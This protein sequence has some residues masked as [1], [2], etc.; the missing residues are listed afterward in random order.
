MKTF[1]RRLPKFE[2]V[3]PK[4]A[5]EA[6]AFLSGN[7]GQVKVLAGGTDLIPQLKKREIAKPDWVMELKAIPDLTGISHDPVT[8]LFIGP[9]ATINAVGLHPLVVE[10]IR[11]PLPGSPFN[12]VS[13]GKKSWDHSGKHL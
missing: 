8:G 3:R 10:K 1:Y 11:G 5:D 7:R 13:P 9:L 4:T 12:G 6:L 2:Y